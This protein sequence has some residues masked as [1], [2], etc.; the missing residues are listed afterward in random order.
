MTLIPASLMENTCEC[1]QISSHPTPIVIQWFHAIDELTIVWNGLHPL[2]YSGWKLILVVTT[3]WTWGWL[4]DQQ[5]LI[6]EKCYQQLG[7][8]LVTCLWI[9]CSVFSLI[10]SQICLHLQEIKQKTTY[11]SVD[12]NIL[13]DIF[14]MSFH[15]ITSNSINPLIK[16]Y[17][18]IFPEI[19]IYIPAFH[20]HC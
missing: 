19:H 10:S 12:H 7:H 9:Y 3:G 15:E 8:H 1:L 11:Y 6:P 2:V 18:F 14:T 16:A 4:S 5:E 20:H 17:I 13:D